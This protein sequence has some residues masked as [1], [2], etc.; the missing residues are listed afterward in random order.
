MKCFVE[1]CDV[2]GVWMPVLMLRKTPK[3]KHEPARMFELG[4]CEVHKDRSSLRNF[5]S[6]EGWTKIEK[7][8]REHGH[9]NY[10]QGLTLLD[11]QLRPEVPVYDP[12]ADSAF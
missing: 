6:N 8:L 5:L 2:E 11:W 1:K 10:K 7:F 4:L 12:Y 3:S 9:Q